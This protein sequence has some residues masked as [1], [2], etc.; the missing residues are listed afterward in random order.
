MRDVIIIIIII[1]KSGFNPD[2][3]NSG[4]KGY[5]WRS[6]ICR[7]GQCSLTP[8]Y[9]CD[10]SISE[11]KDMKMFRGRADP[12]DKPTEKISRTHLQTFL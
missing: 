6:W 2:A 7:I 9:V 1:H 11:V 12:K 3:S 8:L 10:S 4:A 5:I